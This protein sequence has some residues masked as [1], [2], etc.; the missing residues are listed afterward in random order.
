VLKRRP[1]TIFSDAPPLKQILTYVPSMLQ[2]DCIWYIFGGNS[3]EKAI[4]YEIDDKI[5]RKNI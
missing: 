1:L 3:R 4:L 5:E 2:N